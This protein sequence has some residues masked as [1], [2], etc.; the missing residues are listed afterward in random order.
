MIDLELGALIGG[1]A[2]AAAAGVGL[3]LTARQ[4]RLSRESDELSYRWRRVDFVRSVVDKL[5]DDE[6]VQFCLRALDWGGGPIPVPSRHRVLFEDRRK[7]MKH[8]A[9]MMERALQ[10]QLPSDW[11]RNREILVY[12]LAFDHFFTA[13]TNVITYG[14]R[15]GEEFTED[16]GLSYYKD[17]IRSPPYMSHRGMSPFFD[18][19][20]KFYPELC[21]LIWRGGDRNDAP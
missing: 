17:L 18:F 15:L 19:V 13:I 12:R 1:L 5:N 21:E 10:V 20:R 3:V 6:E 16:V 2:T 4:I 14:T 7:V 8:D 9:G 11:D